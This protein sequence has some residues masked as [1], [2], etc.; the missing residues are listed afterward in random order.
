[1]LFDQ[2]NHGLRR[3]WAYPSMFP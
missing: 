2:T 1:M 3:S